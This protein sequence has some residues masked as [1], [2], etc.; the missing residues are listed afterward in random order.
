MKVYRL[1]VYW[2]LM[3]GCLLAAS[4]A[5]A[6]NP[7]LSSQIRDLSYTSALEPEGTYWSDEFSN[8]AVAWQ[9]VHTLWYSRKDDWSDRRFV[10]RRSTNRGVS[11]ATPLVVAAES[12]SPGS[13]LIHNESDRYLCV[14]GT[15]VHVV[16][17]RS[18]PI[19]QQRSWY[20]N[21]EYYRS[22]DSGATF[23]P[24]RVLVSSAD[25]WH[26]DQSRI[27]CNPQRVVI[28]YRTR[29][30]WYDNYHINALVSEDKGATFRNTEVVGS[31]DRDGSLEDL[32][33][34]G[35]EVYVLYYHLL[36]DYYYGNFQARIGLASSIEDSHTFRSVFLTT[37]ATD[38]RYYALGTKD[39]YNSPDLA[40]EGSNVHVIWN[41]LDTNYQGTKTLM[42]ARSTDSGL[43]FAAPKVLFKGNALYPGQETIAAKGNYVYILFPTTDNKI[44]LRR[45][46][47][48]GWGFQE[49]Q[50]LSTTGGWWPEVVLDPRDATGATF[51]AFWD[52]PT[53]RL[54]TN[55]AKTFSQPLWSHPIFSYNRLHRSQAI[56]DSV[57][58]LHAT[59]SGFFYSNA[60]CNGICDWDTF[61]RRIPPVPDPSGT[62]IGMRLLTAGATFEDRVDNVQLASKTLGFTTAMTAELWV[63]DLV[64]GIGTGFTDY[65]TPML[66]KQRTLS[67][68]YE[69]G[70]GLATRDYY[71]QR[72]LVADLETTAGFFALSADGDKGLLTPK[73][74]THLAMTY[75]AAVAADNFRLYRNGV[76]VAKATVTGNVVA[77]FGNL[78]V[79]RYGNWLVDEVRL[80]DRALTGAQIRAGKDGPLTGKEVGLNAYYNFN[81]TIKDITGKG[82]DGIMMYKEAFT[83]G[84]F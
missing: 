75:D 23:E 47:T 36:E 60:L 19:T 65:R 20:Y 50:E 52:A 11:W 7:A 54:T 2:S 51:Y 27:A 8:L 82:N 22:T 3:V 31:N 49:A 64:G 33:L 5:N 61:Y 28:A 29:A 24:A 63:K 44:Q 12:D 42:Y 17:P 58:T 67:T 13:S 73:V 76:L 72:K 71:G 9:N 6:R 62:Q 41:Q 81:N 26:I 70:Y 14:A 10:Y 80:W 15:T 39:L 83:A 38:G 18:F 74:W 57:G 25:V 59:T 34:S 21:L 68:G 35:T 32:V 56:V 77:G 37:P 40:V 53:Y 4:S 78:F 30:N 66:F 1:L 48:S 43:S 69:P 45:S 55:A 16:I 79:G 84:K 46:L